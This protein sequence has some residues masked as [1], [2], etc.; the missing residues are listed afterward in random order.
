MT[1]LFAARNLTKHYGATRALDGASVALE[2]GSVRGLLGENGAG[3]STLLHVLAGLI[4]PDAGTLELDGK[5]FVA[6]D[7]PAARAAGI[8]LVHQELAIAPDLSVE[9]NVMLGGE[10]THAGFVRRKSQRDVARAAL[11][12]LGHGGLDLDARC[13][14]LPLALRQVVEIARALVHQ[15]RV[16]LLDEPTSSLSAR[17]AAVLYGVVRELART[18]VAVAW[19]THFLGEVEAACDTWSVLRDGRVVAEGR[20][21]TTTRAELIA[22]FCGREVAN[23]DESVEEDRDG[24]ERPRGDVVLE[25]RGLSGRRSPREVDLF[26]CRGEI[27]GPFGLVGSGRSRLLR[28]IFGL[29]K[30]AR[31]DARLRGGTH[32]DAYAVLARDPRR[33]VKAGVAFASEERGREGVCADLSVAENVTLARLPR[34]ARA[35]VLWTRAWKRSARSALQRVRCDVADTSRPV[36][37][38]SGGNQQKVVLAR[39]LHQDAE[40]LL[41]D[42][43][44][45]GI[46]METQREVTSILRELAAEGRSILLASSSTEELLATCDTIGVMRGGRLVDVRSARQWTRPD[47]LEVAGADGDDP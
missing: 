41:L 21:G 7:P 18:G 38:L 29:E 43:P 14:D 40:L 17:D 39:C 30:R 46:D 35:G 32:S 15:A 25:V 33:S 19:V 9:A 36:S 2:A 47:L 6:R 8:V 4:R 22:H 31:G 28:V 20:A 11:E 44:T 26:L 27:F 5:P 12:R 13:G 34:H 24:P 42:E 10:R 23:E 37:T 3:K 1:A 45:R 16:V